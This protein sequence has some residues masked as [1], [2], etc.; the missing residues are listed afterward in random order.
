MSRFVKVVCRSC[1][2]EFSAPERLKL[3][4]CGGCAGMVGVA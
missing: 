1:G 2:V 4:Y 3:R